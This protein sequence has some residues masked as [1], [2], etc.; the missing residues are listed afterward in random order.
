MAQ[1]L[2]IHALTEKRAEISGRI[3]DLEERIRQARADLAH[4]DAT[5]LSL[6]RQSDGFSAFSDHGF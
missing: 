6:S 1:S 2:I 4:I 3:A 5:L